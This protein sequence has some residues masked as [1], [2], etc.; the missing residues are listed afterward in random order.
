MWWDSRS[1]PALNS[2]SAMGFVCG[3]D[4]DIIAGEL[5]KVERKHDPTFRAVGS[6]RLSWLWYR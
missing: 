6:G 1:M 4:E 2:N 5:S 3:S